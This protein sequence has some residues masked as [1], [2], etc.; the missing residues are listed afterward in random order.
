[1]KKTI[2]A[3][4]LISALGVAHAT[5]ADEVTIAIKPSDYVADTRAPAVNDKLD[6]VDMSYAKDAIGWLTKTESIGHFTAMTAPEAPVSIDL[7]RIAKHNGDSDMYVYWLIT[8]NNYNSIIEAFKVINKAQPYALRDASKSDPFYD[9]NPGSDSYRN[10]VI[11]KC[12]TFVHSDYDIVHYPGTVTGYHCL[13]F[14][15]QWSFRKPSLTPI[16]DLLPLGNIIAFG[17]ENDYFQGDRALFDDSNKRVGFAYLALYNAAHI[18]ST[19]TPNEYA[20]KELKRHINNVF[21]VLVDSAIQLGKLKADSEHGLDHGA[22]DKFKDK[23]GMKSVYRDETFA[24]KDPLTF[25]ECSAINVALTG[26]SMQKWAESAKKIPSMTNQQNKEACFTGSP[27]AS[28]HFC[29][30]INPDGSLK[31]F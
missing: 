6:T 29:S 4:A 9:S 14:E 17:R 1:M 22:I 11:N 10:Q 26:Q 30:Q 3:L 21:N 7:D 31:I 28:A 2:L 20:M 8:N 15:R 24:F 12:R 19:G 27:T 16:A 13:A 25:E 5:N 18:A 23:I